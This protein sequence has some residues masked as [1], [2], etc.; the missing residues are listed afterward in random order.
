MFEFEWPRALKH[1][2]ENLLHGAAW[3]VA[4]FFTWLVALICPFL[5]LAR[6]QRFAFYRSPLRALDHYDQ[7]TVLLL[8]V[9]YALCMGVLA[10]AFL[11]T[12]H[13]ELNRGRGKLKEIKALSSG[14]LSPRAPR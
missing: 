6:E 1:L 12:Y 5:F 2:V 10:A 7:D 4:W 14:S 11:Y 9:A 13:R 3:I 8:A